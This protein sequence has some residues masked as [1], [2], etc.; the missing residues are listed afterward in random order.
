MTHNSSIKYKRWEVQII[1]DKSPEK[2]ILKLKDN[3]EVD[4]LCKRHFK[5]LITNWKSHQKKCCNI[6][7]VH[8]KPKTTRMKLVSLEVAQDTEIYTAMKV[9]PCQQICTECE[10]RLKVHHEEV[11]CHSNSYLIISGTDQTRQRSH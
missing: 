7:S 10:K 9:I 8:D 11:Y 6:F 2:S 4:V 3:L 5:N 1:D